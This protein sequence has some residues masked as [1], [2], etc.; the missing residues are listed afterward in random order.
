M[1]LKN[2]P[3]HISSEKNTLKILELF[4]GIG[5]PRKALE[6]L[7]FDIK[8]I[9]YV[10]ILPYAVMAYNAIFDN[11]YKPQDIRLW[12]MDVDVLIH[13]SPCQDFSKNGLN[14]INTGRSILYEKTLSI[15]GEELVR[16]PRIV[17]WEN[18][19]NLLSKGKKVCHQVHHQHYLDTMEA[20]GYDNYYK[21]LNAADYGLPQSR[22]RVYTISIL[23]EALLEKEFSFPQAIPLKYDIRYFL[24]KDVDFEKYQLSQAEQSLFF[25]NSNGKMC[26]REATKLGYKEIDEFDVINVEFPS[27]KTRRGRVGKRVAK[28]L[29]THPRQAIY[30][31]GKFRL[32]TAKEHI[33][34]MGFKDKD[35]NHMIKHG[36]TEQ[37]ISFLAGN[38]ICVLVLEA[39]FKELEQMAL[40]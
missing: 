26:V 14:N 21:I 2:Q 6:N 10:E 35:Y 12:N 7:G 31:N 36:I 4:G 13:G 16:K 33:R 24:E 9:D 1:S 5:A 25:R 28:T 34:L 29:T 17:I 22:E 19:P 8:S 20:Y 39:I 32:L 18:V 27:S 15:I 40:I 11:G 3:D 38:S 23:K 37:Q 30:Y